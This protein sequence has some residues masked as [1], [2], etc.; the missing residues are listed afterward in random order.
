MHIVWVN[1]DADFTGG[2]EKY[3]SQSV[4]SLAAQNVK[5]TLLYAVGSPKNPEFLNQ[6]DQA[7]PMVDVPGQLAALSPDLIY[8]HG[9]NNTKILTQILSYPCKKLRF[10]H[11]QRAL[12]LREH[13][14]TTIGSQPCD[15]KLGL[16]CYTCLGFLK[17]SDKPWK[18]S[19]RALGPHQQALDLNKQ[20]DRVV[21]GS[22]YMA[23]QLMMHDFDSEKVS[24]IPLFSSQ[25]EHSPLRILPSSDNQTVKPEENQ[26]ILFVGQ[27]VRGKGLD[28]LLEAIALS[29]HKVHLVICGTGKMEQDYRDQTVSLG[30]TDQVRFLGT[31]TPEQLRQHYRDSSVVV[32]PSRAPETF[33][34]VGLEALLNGTPVITSNTGGMREWFKPNVNGL[35]FKP[36][37]Q[38]K[39]ASVIDRF[40]SDTKLQKR[41]RNMIASADYQRFSPVVH[42]EQVH[43]LMK[44]LVEAA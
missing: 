3:I 18:V 25:A 19:F 29:K 15:Q 38:C 17:R 33:C 44:N 5:S 31:Q 10:F 2:C 9:L 20:F 4:I 40:L 14:Y 28:T 16:G 39:L 36:N 27:L 6:F 30:L 35:S 41:L 24:V 8:V 22:E 21:V 12:C 34:L 37:D 42:I 23:K 11:D 32:I 13:K 1:E 7:F 43:S 26:Q